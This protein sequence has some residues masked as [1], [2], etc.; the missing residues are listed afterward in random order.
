MAPSGG[1]VTSSLRNAW[2][3]IIVQRTSRLDCAA[4]EATHPRNAPMRVSAALTASAQAVA[5][6]SASFVTRTQ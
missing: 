6:D 4:V 1:L 5:S 3:Q 2:V